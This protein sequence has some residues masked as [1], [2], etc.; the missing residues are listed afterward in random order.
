[1][2]GSVATGTYTGTGAAINVQIGFVPAYV[3]IINIT[4]ADETYEWFNSMDAGKAIK[5]AAA[6]GTQ[7]TNGVSPYA[8]TR[9][10]DGAGFT[11]GTA[12]SVDTKVYAYVAVSAEG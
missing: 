11:V 7:A 5:T 2:K 1:M 6:V 9:G 4:D 10:G 3:R 8:G 12:I